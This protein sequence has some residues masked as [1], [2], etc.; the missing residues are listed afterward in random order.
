[1]KISTLELKNFRN[2]QN[3]KLDFGAGSTLILGPNGSGKTNILEAIYLLSTTKSL[4]TQ[5]DREV[6][7]HDAEFARVVAKVETEGD[8][9]SLEF[10]I[11]K[12]PQTENT[13]TRKIKIDKKTK[14]LGDFIGTFNVV[15]F[16]PHD[17]ELFTNSP[18]VRRRHLDIL[19][20][21]ID[22]K[23]KNAHSEYTKAVRQR[24]KIL[25]KIREWHGTFEEAGFW[26]DK[27]LE[28]GR[29]LQKK[30]Q[31]FLNFAEKNVNKH[32]ETL[33]AGGEKTN[34]EYIKSEISEERFEK[35]KMAEVASAQTLIGPHRDDF[36]ITRDGHNIAR[37]GS[38][39]ERR[40]TILGLKLCE[41]D[42]MEKEAG[43]RPVLL[44]D[45]IFSELDE[46]HREGVAGIV[47]LQQTIVT[48]A[49]E[50]DAKNGFEVIRL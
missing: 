12:V 21:Q 8:I 10:V 47:D 24:N 7:A 37:Y 31:E 42:F 1:M 15:L 39:G 23:Y 22:K 33:D 11:S 4:R 17:V 18:S 49:D 50:N 45:D 29:I 38:R 2:H 36:L 35:Y 9:K 19:L 34:I 13:S 5:F 27:V 26:T 30:R 32:L 48:T 44:L 28:T 3:L 6:I 16:S 40:A 41:L 14:Q 46:K 20:T 25:E 43:E